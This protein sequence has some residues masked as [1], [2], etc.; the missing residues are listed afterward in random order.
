MKDVYCNITYNIKNE[1][2]PHIASSLLLDCLL[3]KQLNS[4]SSHF[5]GFT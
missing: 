5:F 3:S 1:K 4:A 2:Q